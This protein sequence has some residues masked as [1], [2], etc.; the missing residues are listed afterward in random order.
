MVL[1]GWCG[2]VRISRF[3]ELTSSVSQKVSGLRPQASAF[4]GIDVDF[5]LEGR[6]TRTTRFI[7]GHAERAVDALSFHHIEAA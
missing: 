5:E 7:E 1:W 4:V 3:E 6:S 2:S